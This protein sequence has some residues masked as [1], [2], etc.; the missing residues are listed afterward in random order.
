MGGQSSNILFVAYSYVSEKKS[1]KG[2]NP[3]L[4]LFR[5]QIKKHNI[6]CTVFA[7]YGL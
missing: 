3:G 6:L 1:Y 2:G 4:H 5:G 7:D